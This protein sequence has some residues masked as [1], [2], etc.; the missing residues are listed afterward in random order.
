MN[1]QINIVCLKWGT[2]FSTDYVNRLYSSVKR[3]TTIPFKFH[4]FTENSKE[5]N[6]EIIVQNLP[7]NG[8]EGWW[9]KVY[10]F[11]KDIKI[12]LGEKIVFFDLD[13]VITGNIDEILLLEKDCLI[14]VRDLLTG[15]IL[16]I[17]SSDNRM[18]SCIM[19]WKHG[20]LN[21]VW[22]NFI[23]NPAESIKSV[24][25]HGDQR[26]IESQIPQK[27]FI[28]D[29][30]PGQIVSFKV[31]CLK[32]LPANARIICYHGKPSIEESITFMGKVWKFDITPQRWVLDYWR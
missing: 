2:K 11:S 3:N 22:D 24:I 25:P 6:P 26:W 20:T 17:K 4:C 1:Q 31:H 5:L 15:I 21:H 30:L 10:L 32:G 18:Q 9:N 12:P 13:T 8:L 7:N 16:S 29:L 23:Q 28:Q 14:T 19:I 27:E